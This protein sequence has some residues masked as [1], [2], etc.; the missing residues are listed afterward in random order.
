LLKLVK[1]NIFVCVSALQLERW[2]RRALKD[3]GISPPTAIESLQQIKMGAKQRGL[4]LTLV[5]KGK[6]PKDNSVHCKGVPHGPG[7]DQDA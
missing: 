7:N 6:A 3:L 4:W 5:E 1:A 2:R